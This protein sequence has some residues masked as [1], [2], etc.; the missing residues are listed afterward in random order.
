VRAKSRRR[1]GP[2]AQ[3]QRAEVFPEPLRQ[4]RRSLLV[5]LL[6]TESRSEVEAVLRQAGLRLATRPRSLD[7]LAD[8]I[9][10]KLYKSLEK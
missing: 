9:A 6:A 5:L 7:A 4:L 8:D 3:A 2:L 1:L 10:L